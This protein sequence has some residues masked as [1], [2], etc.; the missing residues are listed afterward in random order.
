[1]EANGPLPA[2]DVGRV[3]ALRAVA[4]AVLTLGHVKR[5]R[6]R[7]RR[8]IMKEGEGALVAVVHVG[9][10]QVIKFGETLKEKR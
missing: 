5:N 1:M 3:R 6:Q 9:E 2:L 7:F 8:L 4:Q 10:M